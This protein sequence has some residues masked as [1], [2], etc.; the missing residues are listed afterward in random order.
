M[1]GLDAGWTVLE[2][3][4]LRAKLVVRGGPLEPWR[5]RLP[6]VPLTTDEMREPLNIKYEADEIHAKRL[7]SQH[8]SVSGAVD[9]RLGPTRGVVGEAPED[10]EGSRARQVALRSVVCATR[11]EYF[12]KDTLLRAA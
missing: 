8:G 1:G 7:M 4:R 5:T 3:T 12:E 6:K 9:I 11:F 2:G 10:L